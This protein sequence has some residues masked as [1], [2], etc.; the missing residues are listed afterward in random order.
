MQKYS[1]SKNPWSNDELTSK[2]YLEY[3]G[4]TINHCN[5]LDFE[6]SK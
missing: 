6:V 5:S 3:K 1:A 4:D 2:E